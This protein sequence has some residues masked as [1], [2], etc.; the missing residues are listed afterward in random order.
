MMY[1]FPPQIKEKSPPLDDIPE[2]LPDDVNAMI[3]YA[4]NLS[5]EDR[6]DANALLAHIAFNL[7]SKWKNYVFGLGFVI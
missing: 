3:E 4:W 1:A 2:G 6:P 7:I 5:V